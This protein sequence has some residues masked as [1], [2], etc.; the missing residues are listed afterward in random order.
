MKEEKDTQKEPEE[1]TITAEEFNKLKEVAKEKDELKDKYLRL[2]AEFDNIRKRLEKDKQ[3]FIKF[4][5]EGIIVELLNVLDDLERAVELT[6]AKHEDLPALLKGVE[7]VLAH[8]Y[9]LLKEYGVK[10][11][12]AKGRPFDPHYHEALMQVENKKLPQHTII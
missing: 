7:M 10:P 5:N 11:V 2:L 1:V 6:Q 9:E 3:D 8:L 4:A 12:E